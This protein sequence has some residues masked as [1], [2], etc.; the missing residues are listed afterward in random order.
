MHKFKVPVGGMYTLS[1]SQIDQR[2]FKRNSGYEYSEVRMILAEILDP[3]EGMYGYNLKYLTGCCQYSTRDVYLEQ[4][5][6]RNKT[7]VVFN[8]VT[9]NRSCLE[10]HNNQYCVTGYGPAHL[11][12]EDTSLEHEY[13]E[14][15][16]GVFTQLINY[17]TIQLPQQMIPGYKI[18]KNVLKSDFGYLAIQIHNQ[19]EYYDFNMTAIFEPAKNYT[20]LQPDFGSKSDMLVLPGQKRLV[21]ARINDRNQK[22]TI[23]TTTDISIALNKKQLLKTC[24]AKGQITRTDNDLIY[25]KCFDYSEGRVYVYTND[26]ADQ[27][28][29]E[30]LEIDQ[31]GYEIEGQKDQ[32][33]IQF[34][35]GPK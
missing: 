10:M 4:L 17:G 11:R 33:Q 6:E 1:T 15:I 8:Q 3:E 32:T 12:F 27:F 18:Y 31:E 21:V 35:L 25:S 30:H 2:M 9:W 28:L 19:E 5:L 23:P 20:L 29:D 14:L 24:M 16:S 26:T 7:Y 34:C 13:D 22:Y